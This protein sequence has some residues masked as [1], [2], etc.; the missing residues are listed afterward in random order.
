MNKELNRIAELAGLNESS[1]PGDYFGAPDDY[2]EPK[3]Y[4]KIR[5]R[6]EE[7]VNIYDFHSSGSEYK[8]QEND[9]YQ[10]I[11]LVKSALNKIHP[12]NY[13]ESSVESTDEPANNFWVQQH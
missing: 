12:R 13:K 10:A 8:N 1:L 4:T 7:V 9:L 3:Y 2:W 11:Q 5:N 6:L